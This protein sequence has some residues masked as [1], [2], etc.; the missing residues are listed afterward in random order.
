MTKR[1]MAVLLFRLAPRRAQ[2][3][4]EKKQPCGL[5]LTNSP[6]RCNMQGSG[7]LIRYDSCP[8][9]LRRHARHHPKDLLP[10]R[11]P[12]AGRRDNPAT[13][14]PGSGRGAGGNPR[15]DRSAS[16]SKNP[17]TGYRNR[18][19]S[20]ASDNGTEAPSRK[21]AARARL[22]RCRPRIFSST[23]SRTTS[24]YTVTGRSCPSLCARSDA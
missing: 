13:Q 15:R 8:G 4:S 22:L 9:H 1:F 14:L 20:S 3:V 11:P 2:A 6:A 23:L 17:P 19:S 7:F 12:T 24:R 18:A 16:R 21:S 5:T 10:S